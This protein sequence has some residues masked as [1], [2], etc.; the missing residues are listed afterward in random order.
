[1]M[2]EKHDELYHYGVR[3]MKWGVRRHQNED[4]SLTS[5]GKKHAEK[6]Y[7]KVTKKAI[8]DLRKSYSSMYVRAHNK[9][10]D[11]MNGGE[12]DKFNE[13]QQKRYGPDYTKREGYASDYKK[14]F[15][16]EVVRNMNK[17]LNDFYNSNKYVQ[18][19]RELVEKYGMLDWSEFA[20]NNEAKI[21]EVRRAVEKKGKQ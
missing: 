4:G 16:K 18:K 12:I 21:E 8:K 19:S 13:R 5:S 2:T 1:M 17:N 3:G 7:K 11:K 9:A 14:M 6:D 15:E 20:R 10:A